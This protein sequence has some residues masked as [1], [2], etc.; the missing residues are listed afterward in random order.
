MMGR[1]LRN[2]GLWVVIFAAFILMFNMM[3]HS[4]RVEKKTITAVLN[5]LTDPERPVPLGTTVLHATPRSK[6]GLVR[7]EIKAYS[8]RVQPDASLGLEAE[9]G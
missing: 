5:L 6:D 7:A 9:G 4:G 8:V 2:V 1:N 3:R